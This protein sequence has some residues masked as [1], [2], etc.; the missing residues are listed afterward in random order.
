MQGEA[1]RQTTR[2]DDILLHHRLEHGDHRFDVALIAGR[3]CGRPI[4]IGYQD[5]VA[6]G[7]HLID[8]T[9]RA[10]DAVHAVAELTGHIIVSG[11]QHF[12]A[13]ID[14]AEAGREMELL[15]CQ[16]LHA[17]DAVVGRTDFIEGLEIDLV[18][19]Q[20][21]FERVARLGLKLKRPIEIARPDIEAAVIV[22][23]LDR[24][25]DGDAVD[26][27]DADLLDRK[28]C[29]RIELDVLSAPFGPDRVGEGE[30]S[31]DG[32]VGDRRIGCERPASVGLLDAIVEN[33]RT[34]IHLAHEIWCFVA[35]GEGAL[36]RGR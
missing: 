20:V 5:G 7:V 13:E 15:R 3:R 9:P 17:I 4:G 26:E 19:T 8:V 11:G 16:Q 31:V 12:G 33:D 36:T 1:H 29:E 22:G 28:V 10:F 35:E 21:E 18:V 14:A 2:R 24:I 25:V 23:D 27:I 30:D 6:V 32:S 34:A